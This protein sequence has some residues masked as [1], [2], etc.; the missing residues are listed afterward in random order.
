[1]IW[2][3][4]KTNILSVLIWILTVCKGYSPLARKESR[5]KGITFTVHG[6]CQYLT[7]LNNGDFLWNFLEAIWQAWSTQ[8]FNNLQFIF[9]QQTTILKESGRVLFCSAVF[10]ACFFCLEFYSGICA[11]HLEEPLI[12]CITCVSVKF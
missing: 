1:M 3:Q 12:N 10:R 5:N 2:I 8:T 4:L 6:H 11:I 7:I 9:T